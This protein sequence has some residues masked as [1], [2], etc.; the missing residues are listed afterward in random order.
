MCQ[1]SAGRVDCRLRG[2]QADAGAV[3]VGLNGVDHPALSDHLEF[4]GTH[5]GGRGRGRGGC[6]DWEGG[7]WGLRY[8]RLRSGG[9]RAGKRSDPGVRVGGAQSRLEVRDL[10]LQLAVFGAQIFDFARL[11]KPLTH[12]LP[13]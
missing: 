6:A 7:N 4:G 10:F 12:V 11:A 13:P 2:L 9:Y 5:F 8:C 3:L 1:P